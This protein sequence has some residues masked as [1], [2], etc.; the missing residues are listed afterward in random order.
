MVIPRKTTNKWTWA[1]NYCQIV[2]ILDFKRYIKMKKPTYDINKDPRIIFSNFI[3]R[4]EGI[5][6]IYYI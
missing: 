3:I 6:L 2:Q 1:R 5:F 4:C